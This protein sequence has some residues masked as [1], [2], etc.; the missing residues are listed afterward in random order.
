MSVETLN[1]DLIRLQK[2][3]QNDPIYFL[4][5]VLDVKREHVWGRMKELADSVRDNPRTHVPAGH[6]LSKSYTA[7]RLALWFLYSFAPS[8]VV[9][10]APTDAQVENV[11]WREIRAAHANAKISLGGDVT[12]KKIDLQKETGS[13]W[14]AIGFAT[15]PDTV[16]KEA[17]AF[18]GYHNRHI[19]LIFDEASGV[20]PEIWKAAR[21]LLAGAEYWRW[22]V[23]GNP[24]TGVGDFA[25]C[26]EDD[27]WNT[28]TI[29]VK[30]T[31]NFKTGKNI[32]PGISG[33]EYEE[34]IRREYGI[35][36]REYKI[37][38]LG[39]FCSHAVDGSYYGPLIADLKSR[40]HIRPHLYDA[41]LPVFTSWDI[42]YTTAIWFFQ[43][44][45]EK[46]MFIRYY[47]DSGEGVDTYCDLLRTYK[48][49]HSYSYA[50]HFG[51]F[52]I[53]SGAHKQTRGETVYEVAKEHG[54]HFVKL[55]QEKDVLSGI[56]RTQKM[57][58][59]AMFDINDC[60]VGIDAL[61]TYKERQ[62]QRMSHDGKPYFVDVPQKHWGIHCCDAMRYASAALEKQGG[63]SSMT[64]REIMELRRMYGY[65]S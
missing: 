8:S 21:H 1:N 9:T 48:F 23:I 22:L 17:S 4:T 13:K 29:S 14:F 30:D 33:R 51:S 16:T 53:T 27:R 58:K 3:W 19:L 43:V 12:N 56:S 38:V 45:H 20:A 46:P 6:S 26:Y 52:D 59:N 65:A 54:V 63:G 50:K 28:I 62:N 44:K 18:A 42:G 32:V 55:K 15:K 40:E 11:L 39:E 49:K 34:E 37:R 35:D 2:R 24:L 7:A 57:L 60:A 31:P 64:Q 5:E 10:T 41:S 61:V 36:H 47:E 25:D